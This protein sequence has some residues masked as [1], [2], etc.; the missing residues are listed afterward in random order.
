[1]R[2]ES[3]CAK[4]AVNFVEGRITEQDKIRL[5]ARDEEHFTRNGEEGQKDLPEYKAV[6][7][8]SSN[9]RDRGRVAEKHIHAEMGG[10]VVRKN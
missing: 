1:M 3:W 5:L 4:E 6:F 9:E 7:K 10:A 2:L 8:R